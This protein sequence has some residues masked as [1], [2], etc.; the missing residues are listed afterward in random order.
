MFEYALSILAILAALAALGII[1]RSWVRKA[2]HR[3]AAAER[4]WFI[5]TM[6]QLIEQE[7]ANAPQ[8]DMG[9]HGSK[10]SGQFYW[11]CWIDLGLAT[12]GRTTW[13]MRYACGDA[14]PD[15]LT[16][17]C[18]LRLVTLARKF[19]RQETDGSLV[20]WVDHRHGDED[21][22]IMPHDLNVAA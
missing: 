15:G 7:T 19:G 1:V 11:S 13:Q 8:E 3:K 20:V 5:H 10:Q 18:W 17:D 16:D 22:N 14:K 9:G 6:I 2:P 21:C 4:S 12:P